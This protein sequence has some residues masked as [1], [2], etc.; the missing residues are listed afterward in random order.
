ML[1]NR[2]GSER[3]RLAAARRVERVALVQLRGAIEFA[4]VGLRQP[5]RMIL[6]QEGH[7]IA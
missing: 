2:V 7:K 4:C 5:L 1:A 3:Q 6:A